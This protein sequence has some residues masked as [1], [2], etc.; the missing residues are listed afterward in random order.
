VQIV[1]IDTSGKR[2]QGPD[3]EMQEVQI[4]Y[5]LSDSARARSA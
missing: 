3:G 1:S 2:S 5:L 4:T